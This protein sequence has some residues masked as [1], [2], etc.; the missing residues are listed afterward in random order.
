MVPQHTATMCICTYLKVKR[1][2]V[3]GDG[4]PPG[5]VLHGS[6]EEGLRRERGERGERRE[7]RGQ[8]QEKMVMMGDSGRH[9]GRK[10]IFQGHTH[11]PHLSEVES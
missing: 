1:E 3:N 7:K 11:R 4:V 9:K 5:V 2:Q 10:G 6:R 8:G